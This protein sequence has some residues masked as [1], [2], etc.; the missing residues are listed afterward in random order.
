MERQNLG[1]VEQGVRMVVGSL[2]LLLGI[3]LLV[4]GKA[5][6]ASGAFGTTL[7]IA[8]STCS[9]PHLPDTAQSTAAWD[10]LPGGPR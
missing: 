2:P 8:G 3:V 5:S 10:G 6:L 7:V 9:S 1:R 4:L